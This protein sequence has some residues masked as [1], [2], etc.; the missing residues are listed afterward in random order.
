VADVGAGGGKMAAVDGGGGRAGWERGAACC[1][2][3]LS[4]FDPVEGKLPNKTL[5]V[6]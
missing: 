6:S 4:R 3:Y 2:N 5:H 1:G